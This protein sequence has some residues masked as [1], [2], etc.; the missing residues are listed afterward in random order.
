MPITKRPPTLCAPAATKTERSGPHTGHNTRPVE[1][2]SG[3]LR[4]PIPLQDWRTRR[5]KNSSQAECAG[6]IPVTRSTAKNLATQANWMQFFRRPFVHF[7]CNYAS[8]QEGVVRPHRGP[9]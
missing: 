8:P 6:S 1:A 5:H 9:G 2:T 4:P 3:Q 7:T